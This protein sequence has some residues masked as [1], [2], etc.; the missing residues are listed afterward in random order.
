MFTFDLDSFFVAIGLIFTAYE[1]HLS[2]KK[3]FIQIDKDYQETYEKLN[4]A[5]EDFYCYYTKENFNLEKIKRENP[6]DY[7]KIL[8][9]EHRFFWFC[10]YQ[11]LEGNARKSVPKYLRKDW[12][13]AI[14][15]SMESKVHRQVWESE[16]HKTKFFGHTKFHKFIAKAIKKKKSRIEKQQ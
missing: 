5:R 2:R 15:D 9:W 13:I 7:Q 3:D 6:E 16:I 12:N 14:Q 11:W 1:L 8:S 10:F 4:E